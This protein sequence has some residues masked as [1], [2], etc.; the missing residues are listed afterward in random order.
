MAARKK[1][2]DGKA[3]E[4]K[5]SDTKR[6][7]VRATHA[8]TPRSKRATH[9]ETPRSKRRSAAPPAKTA[10]HGRSALWLYGGALA[11][12]AV[13]AAVVVAQRGPVR[14]RATN[15][16]PEATEVTT[17]SQAATGAVVIPEALRVRV[18]ERRPHDPDAFT[19]GLL[20]H[21][22]ELYESTGLEGESSLRRVDLASGEVRQRVAVDDALFAEGLALV[23][24]RLF[25]I[26]WQN[27]LA[28]VY[29]RVTFEKV[30]EHTYEGEGWGLCYDGTHLVMSDGSDQLFFRDPETFEVQR[31]VRVTKVGRPLRYLNE[32]ECVEGKVWANVWQRD[33]IVRIDPESG[34][35]EATVDASRL[36]TPEERRRTDVLNGIA[37]LPDRQRFLIT[38]KLWPWTFEVELV[39]R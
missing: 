3:G 37:W 11:F 16:A 33:E 30:A 1:R 22:G 10:N 23:G 35:V 21:E 34:V 19:Q 28:L 9:A 25:Q 24:D 26:T 14:E 20:V 31:A 13:V 32:L 36:L 17:V 38:G 2:S 4:S 12:F 7:D 18:V 15:E 5:K 39:A 27:H 8:E 6:S 29:D